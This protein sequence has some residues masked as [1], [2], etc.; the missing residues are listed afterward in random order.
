MINNIDFV[1]CGIW[2]RKCHLILKR[3]M[4]LIFTFHLQWGYCERSTGPEFHLICVD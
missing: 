1:Y 4:N 3:G 2:W